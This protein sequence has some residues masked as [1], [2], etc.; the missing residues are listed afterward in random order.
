M[1]ESSVQICIWSKI[2]LAG[3]VMMLAS[4]PGTAEI[5]GESAEP[6]L[7]IAASSFEQELV[8]VR[9]NEQANPQTVMVLRSDG[10][11]WLDERDL[12]Q[13]RI[14]IPDEIQSTRYE[15]AR[16]IP[17]SALP[18]DQ[19]ALNAQRGELALTLPAESFLPQI[20]SNASSPVVP[21]LSIPGAYL[22]YDL[23]GQRTL[24]ISQVDSR[25]EFGLFNRYGTGSVSMLG[26]DLTHQRELIRL[27]AT[28]TLDRPSDMA[29]L[30]IG[31]TISRGGSWGRPIRFG[32]LQWSTNFATRP[33]FIAFP[34]VDILGSAALPSTIDVF[35]NN[36]RT[37]R[38]EVEPGPFS[39][40]NLPVLTGSGEARL[41]IRDLFGRE[42]AIVQPYYVSRNLLKPGLSDYSYELGAERLNY[43]FVSD[44]YGSIMAAGTYRYGFSE[45]LTGELHAE[46]Q[47]QRQTAGIGGVYLLGSR[48][49]VDGAIAASTSQLGEGALLAL[50]YDSQGRSFSY[51]G[52]TQR[53]T[54][55]FSQIGLLPGSLA[56][57]AQSSVFFAFHRPR[58]GSLGMTY[59]KQD[60][61]S[62]PDAELLS[63][64]YS[65]VLGK[66]WF[67]S[68]NA[69]RNLMEQGDFL[70]GMTLVHTL[71]ARTS[72]SLNYNTRPG[73]DQMLAEVQQNLPA[74]SGLGY[75]LLAG[76]DESSRVEAGLSMQN[77]VGTYIFEAA[78]FR[79]QEAYR[80]NVRGSLA[81]VDHGVYASRRLGDSFAVVQTGEFADVRVY[82]ENQ[83]MGRTNQKGK[84]LIPGLRPYQR[85]LIRVEPEDFPFE[86]QVDQYEMEAVPYF[87]SADILRFPAYKELSAII[88]LSLPDGKPLPSGARVYLNDHPDGHPV[89]DN[90]LL[91]IRG[92]QKKNRLLAEWAEHRCA[93]SLDY[94]ETTEPI[95]E[96]GR[97]TCEPVQ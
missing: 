44:D 64:N 5:L 68:L 42:Q 53:T 12:K 67:F 93:L 76:Y 32:G 14:A 63:A 73:Q 81:F 21:N 31:D 58:L 8:E 37:F 92:L 72:A 1:M 26:R 89:A 61:R 90:G 97:F 74:G 43:G 71:G 13:W 54:R 16:Y 84:I 2:S 62:L 35:I 18:I 46:M 95:P 77:D 27:D 75:R 51:G 49:T 41:V 52:R 30:R 83:L 24:G 45:R 85:N 69:F 50:G 17:L 15:G 55:D 34:Q 29:S 23:F 88:L 78:R 40:N 79:E 80:A 82:A 3:L 91:Y 48:A 36:V 87:R 66:G 56:P 22:N 11:V 96:L 65:R 70:V 47:R 60:N 28:W 39:L 38:Q 57:A 19:Y 4:M 20:L 7:S 10:E 59:I 33:D 25:L 94:P 6:I 9:V 86:A